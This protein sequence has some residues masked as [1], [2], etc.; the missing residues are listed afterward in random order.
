MKDASI[1]M[2]I[3]TSFMAVLALLTPID[4]YVKIFVFISFS[5]LSLVFYKL[6]REKRKP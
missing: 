1:L 4:I 5:I 6:S 2:S 3:T